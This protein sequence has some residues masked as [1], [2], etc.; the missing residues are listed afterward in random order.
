MIIT[1]K[2]LASERNNFVKFSACLCSLDI[3]AIFSTFVT[4]STRLATSGPNSSEIS[5]N[6]T[7][8]SS[9]TSCN[10]ALTTVV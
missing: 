8:V 3:K 7:S 9:T 1:L 2:S 4:P 6:F 5:D 10:S